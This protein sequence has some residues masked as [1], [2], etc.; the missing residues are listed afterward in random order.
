MEGLDDKVEFLCL[1][2]GL[3]GLFKEQGPDGEVNLLCPKCGIG[4]YFSSPERA[5]WIIAGLK[6]MKIQCFSPKGLLIF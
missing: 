2:C 1:G 5:G 3:Q 4:D 6:I